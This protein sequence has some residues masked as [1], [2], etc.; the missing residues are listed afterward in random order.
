MDTTIK[1]RENKVR[2]QLKDQ[3]YTLEKH[4][5]HVDIYHIGCYRIINSFTGNIEAGRDFDMTL[6]DVERF[7][8][9]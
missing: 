8:A 3:G 1:N 6:E 7:A 9:E 2:K 4:V 5:N